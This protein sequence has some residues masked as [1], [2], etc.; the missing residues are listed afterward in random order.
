MKRI[1]TKLHLFLLA[2]LLPVLTAS[3]QDFSRT[4][5]VS[6]GGVLRLDMETGGT[7]SVV[8][9][10]R[11]E[12]EVKIYVRGRDS[13]EIIVDLEELRNGV[14]IK[15]EFERRNSRADVEVE[16]SVP[17]VFDLDLETMGGEISV[18]G[19]E[20]KL[21]GETM[22]GEL[23]LRNLTGVIEFETMGGE[24]TLEDSDVSG[25]VQTMGGEISLSNVSGDVSA[26]T[27]GGEVS[28]D[29]S[30]PGSGSGDAVKINTMGG[31]INV[32]R[33]ENGA[34]LET[35]GGEI[36]IGYARHYVVASTMG[37][38]IMIEEVDGWVEASTMGGEIEVHMI[39]NPDEGDRHV[40]LS[41]MGGDIMLTVPAGLSMDIDA[42]ITV[43]GRHDEDDFEIRSDFDLQVERTEADGRRNR[44]DWTISANG[45]TGSGK[46]R[47][48][49]KTINGDISILRSR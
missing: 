17:H 3:A 48:S 49:I 16:V 23:D 33:A 4:F 44:G 34:E 47:I 35:M 19:V 22:G 11:S 28:Y 29:N 45:T 46:H 2:V 37:G 6:S 5:S 14:S 1:S 30:R 40:E 13:D 41:S 39:G 36:S 43:S 18:D 31:E 38:E 42:E 32:D 7:I 10:N 21:V 20:G 24:I 8:G 15:T 12:V 9:W 27:M 26:S 25:S